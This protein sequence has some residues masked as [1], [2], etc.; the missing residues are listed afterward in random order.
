VERILRRGA[1]AG[2]AVRRL[3]VLAARCAIGTFVLLLFWSLAPL[4]LG[5]SSLV[6]MSGSMAPRIQPGDIV[7]TQAVDA[8]ALRTGQV[9]VV[10]NP[11]YPGTL[12][13]HRLVRRAAD[14]QLITRGD[15]NPAED[16]TP[17]APG[18]VRGLPRLRVPAVGLPVVWL[19]EGRVGPL[20]LAGLGFAA[21]ASVACLGDH[22]GARPRRPARRGA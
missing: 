20:V 18:D 3:C 6:V 8:G 21:V 10:A 19:R 7:I 14:G 5:W 11:A 13:I 15:A 16:S 1:G 4:A 2:R 22:P 17:S 12:L 9:I